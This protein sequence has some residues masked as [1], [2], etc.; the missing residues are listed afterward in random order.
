MISCLSVFLGVVGWLR[1]CATVRLLS[2]VGGTLSDTLLSLL[3]VGSTTGLTLD[4]LT[5]VAWPG[6]QRV[7]PALPLIIGSEL[8]LI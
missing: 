8:H 6:I 1:F 5:V 4:F 2:V 3:W 7:A